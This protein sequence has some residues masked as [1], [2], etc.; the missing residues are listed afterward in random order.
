VTKRKSTDRFV[1]LKR[2]T[3]ELP[4]VLLKDEW[5]TRCEDLATAVGRV[6]VEEA[7]QATAK[8]EMK[9]RLADLVEQRTR[10]SL[11]VKDH[12]EHRIIECLQT[13]DTSTG[14]VA[15]TRLDT[16]EQVGTRTASF[17]EMQRNLPTIDEELVIE[18]APAAH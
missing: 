16:G 14:I 7:A 6:I 8:A 3:R 2:I 4:C 11:V 9:A 12:K 1:D 18:P 10:L 15:I 13:L 5:E 17:D